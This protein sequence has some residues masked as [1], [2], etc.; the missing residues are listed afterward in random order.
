M[1]PE[2]KQAKDKTIPYLVFLKSHSKVELIEELA[3]KEI[4]NI[5]YKN[6]S[7]VIEY[8]ENKLGLK[9][10]NDSK[11]KMPI[12]NGIRNCCMHNNGRC[13]SSLAKISDYKIEE[14][15][16][17]SADDVHDMGIMARSLSSELLE[18]YEKITSR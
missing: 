12:A 17:L 7:V 3:E 14:V 15:I 1:V 10:N 5:L 11:A 9:W 4:R 18:Q 6:I 2:G 8:S 16:R 13:D